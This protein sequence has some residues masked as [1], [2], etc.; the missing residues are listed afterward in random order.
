MWR[1]ILALLGSLAI[2]IGAF[3]VFWPS[4]DSATNTTVATINASHDSSNYT[5]LTSGIAFGPLLLWA[6]AIIVPLVLFALYIW[7]R[8]KAQG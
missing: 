7:Y 2:T 5:G 6:V 4:I 3:V 8:R 1:V